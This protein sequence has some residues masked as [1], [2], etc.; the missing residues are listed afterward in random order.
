MS[1]FRFEIEAPVV[2]TQAEPGINKWGQWQ[3]PSNLFRLSDGSIGVGYSTAQD[4][5]AGFS[6]SYAISRDEGGSWELVEHYPAADGIALRNGDWLRIK[7][8]SGLDAAWVELPPFEKRVYH[9]VVEMDFYPLES[10]PYAL[11]GYRLERYNVETGKWTMERHHVSTPGAY[12]YVS[13]DDMSCH[14]F[15]TP[16]DYLTPQNAYRLCVGPD[17]KV[18]MLSYQ[19][20]RC[21]GHPFVSSAFYVSED[22]G[23]TFRYL[24]HITFDESFEIQKINEHPEK[25]PLYEGF[26]EPDIAF[27][28]D[29]SIICLLRT[30]KES[31]ITRS[32]DDGATWSRPVLFD[33]LGGMPSMAQLA[34]GTIIAVYGRPGVH[35]K[36]TR[37]PSGM[38]WSERFTVLPTTGRT[39]ANC[40]IIPL[41][42]DTALITYSDFEYPNPDGV[43]VKT[44]LSRKVRAYEV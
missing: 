23:H 12:M 13:R 30:G 5:A 18:W 36:A 41:A 25:G 22:D 4:S 40:G 37:D 20:M 14:P 19:S 34:C 35:L 7:M 2:V 42:D 26:D 1:G 39:C 11:R 38:D 10:I 29:G 32:V 43:P 17:G 24:S 31:F 15:G 6:E 21:D 8:M 28:P 33:T 16:G 9:G 27:M 3:F 44:I